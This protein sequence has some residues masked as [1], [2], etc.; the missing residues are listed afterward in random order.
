M[1]TPRPY[2]LDAIDRLRQG[3]RQGAKRLCLVA[4]TGAGKTCIATKIMEEAVS[5]GRRILF[6]AH[7]HELIQQCSNKLRE[8][9][10]YHGRIQAGTYSTEPSAPVQVASVQTLARRNEMPAADLVITDECHHASAGSYQKIQ[11]KYPDAYGLGLTATPW[12]LDG[13]GLGDCYQDLVPVCS[14]LDLVRAGFLVMPTVYAPPGTDLGGLHRRGG[15]FVAGEAAE[16]M[17]KPHLVGDIVDTWKKRALHGAPTVLFAASVAHSLHLTDAFTA[18]GIPAA[19]I[20]GTSSPEARDGALADLA[21]GRVQVLCNVGLL[22]EGWDL[23]ATSTVVLARPTAS[24]SLYLQ[25]VGRGLRTH[26]G[27]ATCIVLDHAGNTMRHGLATDDRAWSLEG[28]PAAKGDGESGKLCPQCFA[29]LP[30][31]ERECPRCE[32]AW[33]PPAPRALIETREGDLVEVGKGAL[34][35]MAGDGKKAAKWSELTATAKEKG[36]KPAWA[37]MRFK[38][39]FG[40]FPKL[41]EKGAA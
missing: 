24:L 20:D 36:Y 28:Q 18:A 4:P 30:S 23:P 2:Q 25:M 31:A 41:S 34:L 16:A 29:Y 35:P 33:P 15:E 32:Y 6:L 11:A 19:H 38:A 3:Y 39:I 40:H 17:D 27:K 10:I 9:G 22:T 12:R 37:M 13:S 1:I 8:C 5:K 7:R 21:A 26:P 14:V